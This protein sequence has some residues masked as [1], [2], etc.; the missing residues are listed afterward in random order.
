M[1]TII[2]IFLFLLS[3]QCFSQEL[4]QPYLQTA[5]ENNPGLKA[6]FNEYMAALEKVPQAGALPDPTLAF[7]YFIQPVETRLGPQ[8]AR[9]S[10]TQMFPWFGTL[11]AQEDAA[12][13][14]AKAKYEMFEEAKSR[15]YYEVKSTWYNL[16]YTHKAIAITRDNIAILNT[17]QKLAWV[18]IEAGKS[19]AVD[20][21]R[22]EMEILDLENQLK[23]LLDMWTTQQVSFNNLLHVDEPQQVDIPDLL[24]MD[25]LNLDREAILD[26]IR[27]N[28]HQVLALEFQEASYQ[29]QQFAADKMGKPKFTIGFDYIFIGE[30]D[31]SMLSP[32][33]SGKDAVVFPM[34][35]ISVPLY[36][37]KYTSMV[38]E[39]AYMQET[40]QEQKVDKVNILESIYEKAYTDYSDANRRIDLHIKQL[41]LAQKALRI[42]ESEYATD[43]KNFE[44]ILRME[45]QV[46]QHSLEL[47]KARTDFNAASAFV[48]YLMGIK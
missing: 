24:N 8:Q 48:T 45:R 33:E 41:E 14:M 28:N 20:E 1:K 30:S 16:Y 22:V 7:G 18:K 27:R 32:G 46:L 15:L 43:G 6:K 4:I 11:G 12:A 42:L 2:K 29:Y 44:E 39:A 36:R 5:A 35:G 13:Q 34:V 21:L 23:L 19:S 38:K 31:N 9:I 3:T 40:A 17:F 10:L 25:E 37:K 47:E 26:S